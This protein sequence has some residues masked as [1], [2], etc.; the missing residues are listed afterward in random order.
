MQKQRAG[1]AGQVAGTPR[2]EGGIKPPLQ[3]RYTK[4]ETPRANAA[5]GQPTILRQT[6]SGNMAAALHKS[7]EVGVRSG[8]GR[9]FE[10][11]FMSEAPLRGEPVIG[12][13]ALLAWQVTGRG[14][15]I[16]QR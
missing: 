8:I 12:E 6:Q 5:R 9:A 1:R 13:K 4:D 14:L 2:E 10:R 7:A 15:S 16:L 11:G 3:G